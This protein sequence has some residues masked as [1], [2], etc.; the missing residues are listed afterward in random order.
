M[1]KKSKNAARSRRRPSPAEM[2][3]PITPVARV[4]TID[5]VIADLGTIKSLLSSLL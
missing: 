5:T 3:D 4:L 1:A 2:T